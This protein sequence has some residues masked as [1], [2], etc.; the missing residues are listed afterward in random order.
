MCFLDKAP[1][2]G[3]KSLPTEVLAWHVRLPGDICANCGISVSANYG[4]R[5]DNHC[6]NDRFVQQNE[7]RPASTINHEQD[8]FGDRITLLSTRQD[9]II[10]HNNGYDPSRF[11]NRNNEPA[12]SKP[13]Y[14]E[15]HARRSDGHITETQSFSRQNHTGES[16]DSL[17]IDNDA[18][19]PDWQEILTRKPMPA[20]YI[21]LPAC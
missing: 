3:S 4:Q 18:L 14:I 13:A 20:H 15:T 6:A 16:I 12:H 1:T 5:C 9:T 17:E 10:R 11:A 7:R 19:D 8:R 2:P 21:D